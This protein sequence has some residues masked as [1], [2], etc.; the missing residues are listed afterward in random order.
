MRILSKWKVNKKKQMWE[1]KDKVIKAE[2][3][4]MNNK[5]TKGDTYE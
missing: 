3:E 4:N 1:M 5:K 2:L